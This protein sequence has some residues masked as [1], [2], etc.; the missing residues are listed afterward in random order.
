MSALDRE[1]LAERFAAVERHLSR[2]KQCLPQVEIEFVPLTDSSDSVI[3]HLW[4]AIQ[5]VIDTASSSC[6]YLKLGTPSSYAD[7][8]LK[9]GTSGYLNHELAIRLSHAA[10]FRNRIVHA[11]EELDMKKVY[12]IAITGPE[13]LRNFFS[14]AR[15]WVP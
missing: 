6:V 5:I 13:D 11:Y 9:L 2:V 15:K 1:I 12:Q 3:L 10:G 7:S 14:Y 8:F 4:Q